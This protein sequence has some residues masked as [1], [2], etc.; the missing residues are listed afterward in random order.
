MDIHNYTFGVKVGCVLVAFLEAC[1][2]APVVKWMIN[3]LCSLLLPG[4][5]LASV[6]LA[7][8]A[9]EHNKDDQQH[10]P[11]CTTYDTIPELQV[12]PEAG[13]ILQMTHQELYVSNFD[14]KQNQE[15]ESSLTAKICAS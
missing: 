14:L 11:T 6:A 3:H 5:L 1:V 10:K 2:N 8:T 9:D 15:F 13:L 7:Q 4:S 12:V